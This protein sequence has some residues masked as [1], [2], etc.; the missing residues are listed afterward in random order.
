MAKPFASTADVIKPKSEMVQLTPNVYAYV[1]GADPS[2]G[3]IVGE[4]ECLVIDARATPSLAREL[5]DAVRKITDKPIGMLALTHYHAVRTMGFGAF[6]N[7]H[8]LASEGTR[9][10][11]MERGPADFKSEAERF[12]RLFEGIG[13]ITGMSI[14]SLTF[15]DS[16]S[17]WL[18]NTEVQLINVGKAHTAG[19]TIVWLPRE[20]IMWGGDVTENHTAPYMGDSWPDEWIRAVDRVRAMRPQTLIAGRGGVLTTAQAIEDTLESTQNYLRTSMAVARKG[21]AAGK[22]LRAI[23]EETRAALA[24]NFGNWPFFEHCMP[25]NVSRCV[26]AVSGVAH[27]R[28]WTAERDKELWQALNG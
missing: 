2:H 9:E 26:D 13:E 19:D 16:M 20:G 6:K 24:N 28:I 4:R 1:S 8:L 17:V 25:F 21:V 18:G 22:P 3:I 12:P 23:F 5:I 7:C 10:F 14:P 11:I 15:K 27:P